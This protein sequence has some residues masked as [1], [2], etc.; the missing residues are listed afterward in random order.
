MMLDEGVFRLVD[1]LDFAR[2]D[3]L[4]LGIARASRVLAVWRG[5]I[6]ATFCPPL[7]TMGL[8]LA[9]LMIEVKEVLKILFP[10]L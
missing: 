1:M 9:M 6:G 5:I 7:P 2:Y 4:F 10:S 8:R 3:A